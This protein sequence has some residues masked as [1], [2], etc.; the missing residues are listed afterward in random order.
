MKVF[1]HE[2]L[3]LTPRAIY[4]DTDMAF[5]V[6]P[7][8]LWREFDRLTGEKMIAFPIQDIEAG[9]QKICTCIM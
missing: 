3:Y 5:L 7:Y 9:P 2:I 1:L 4:F 6:D 8:L